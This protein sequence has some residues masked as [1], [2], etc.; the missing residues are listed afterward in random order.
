MINATRYLDRQVVHPVTLAAKLQ[1]LA[2]VT[3]N[4][5]PLSV[6]HL[7]ADLDDCSLDTSPRTVHLLGDFLDDSFPGDSKAAQALAAAQKLVELGQVPYLARELWL[8]VMGQEGDKHIGDWF[9]YWQAHFFTNEA[10]VHDLPHPG[11][12]KWLQGL[13]ANFPKVGYL[14]GRHRPNPSSRHP[15]GMELGTMATLWKHRFPL[16]PLYMKGQWG[17]DDTAYKQGLFQQLLAAGEVYPLGYIDNEP[18]CVIAHHEVMT[19]ASLPH[20][21][22]W[23]KGVCQKPADLPPDILVLESFE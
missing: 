12:V 17:G 14:T 8:T 13:D 22:V 9:A 1:A 23:F 16:G 6:Q 10:L 19:A 11:V 21:S 5:A 18:S 2:E 20:L 3:T 15:S 4:T 7:L